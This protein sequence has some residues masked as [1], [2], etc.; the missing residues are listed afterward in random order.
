MAKSADDWAEEAVSTARDEAMEQDQEEPIRVHLTDFEIK[1][2]PTSK[3]PIL[4]KTVED[5]TLESFVENTLKWMEEE[6]RPMHISADIL[7]AFF[8]QN[9][10]EELMDAVRTLTEAAIAGG[11]H[12]ITFST[13]RY[14]PDFERHWSAIS[15]VNNA[16]RTFTQKVGEQSLSIHKAFLTPQDGVLVCFAACYEEYYKKSSL[17]KTPSELAV[18][19]VLGWVESHHRHA[20]QHPRRP[21]ERVLAPLPLPLPIAMTKE[22][23]S[24][25][26]MVRL[27]KSRGLFRG[28]RTRSTSRR[29]PPR[30]QSHRTISRER[31]DSL[32]SGARPNGG[33]SPNSNGCLER[34]L[35]QV[36]RGGRARDPYVRERECSRVTT[37][38]SGL[39]REKC[40]EVVNLRVEVETLKLQ[41]EIQKDRQEGEQELEINRLRLEVKKLRETEKWQDAAYDKLARVRDALHC[42]N[43]ALEEEME[44]LRLSKKERRQKKKEKK[45][46]K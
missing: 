34:L 9:Q 18:Q 17:G 14:P 31:A 20:Y 5:E 39:Y 12:R 43:K 30:R 4:F 19:I 41:L 46:R 29:A 28:R 36:Q 15:D 27:L 8:M 26:Y 35:H 3:F 1:Q 6:Q 22:W 11:R 45:S 7:L 10:D 38:I 44:N 13:A 25:E 23:A 21:K 42:D 24:D 40:Q 37:R 16:L 33:R 2:S 32:V